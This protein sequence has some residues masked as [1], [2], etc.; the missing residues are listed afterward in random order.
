LPP[1]VEKRERVIGVK[2][3]VMMRALRGIIGRQEIRING[4]LYP[5]RFA[6]QEIGAKRLGQ[7][8]HGGSIDQLVPA[9][10]PGQSG[11]GQV[12]K[13]QEQHHRDLQPTSQITSFILNNIPALSSNVLYYQQHSRFMAIPKS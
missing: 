7:I 13:S 1:E 4:V 9:L 2:V 10:A 8:L 12:G 11:H 5:V 3:G 6:R